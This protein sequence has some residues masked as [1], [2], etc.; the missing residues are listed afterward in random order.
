MAPATLLQKLYKT[1]EDDAEAFSEKELTDTAI[2]YTIAGS[3]TTSTTLTYLVW[4]VCR[5]PKVRKQLV[6][7]VAALPEDFTQADLKSLHFMSLVIWETLRLF[8]AA[9]TSLPRVVPPGGAGIDGHWLPGGTIVS[10]TAYVLHRDPAVFVNPD[11][12]DPWRWEKPH[13]R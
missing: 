5:H 6:A 3:D 8:A 7:E 13:Q 9:P 1:Q 12:F 4:A 10:T 11:K 2:E